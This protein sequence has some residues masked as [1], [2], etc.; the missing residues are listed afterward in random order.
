[1]KINIGLLMAIIGLPLISLAESDD[2]R[3]TKLE[4]EVKI[5]K[6]SNA[7]LLKKTSEKPGVVIRRKVVPIPLKP[8]EPVERIAEFEGHT[9][10]FIPIKKSWNKAKNDAEKLGGY[11]V[12]ITSE[13]EQNFISEIITINGNVQPTWIGLSDEEV[14]GEWKW[15]N[16]EKVE[17]KDWQPNQPDNADCWG[18]K[19]NCAWLGFCNSPKWDDIWE[20]A[21]FY[22]VVEFDKPIDSQVAK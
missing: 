21:S 16:G 20:H 18:G 3:I 12:C 8:Q 15:V 19:Q 17:Y 9:Y 14:E 6:E 22:S 5:L 1:M 10:K 13:K 11:L 4:E 7:E 2:S